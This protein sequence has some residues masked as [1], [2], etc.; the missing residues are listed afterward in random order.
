MARLKKKIDQLVKKVCLRI[1][2]LQACIP[3]VNT[4]LV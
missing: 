1:W 2:L 3:Y 4:N